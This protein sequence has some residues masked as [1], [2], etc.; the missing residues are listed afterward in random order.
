MVLDVSVDDIFKYTGHDGSEIVFPSL[1]EPNNRRGH[2][3]Y[4][5]IEYAWTRGYATTP[6]AP[7]YAHVSLASDEKIEVYL[8]SDLL[9]WL[10]RYKDL[11]FVGTM[12]SGQGHAVAWN[13]DRQMILDP[14]G[15]A[16]FR[17]EHK[18]DVEIMFLCSR[19]R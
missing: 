3:V 7:E 17:D 10:T 12:P 9:Q 19:L 15:Q 2:T 16:Y 13:K 6:F 4:E 1:K 11:V 5:M 14:N 18:M 8:N